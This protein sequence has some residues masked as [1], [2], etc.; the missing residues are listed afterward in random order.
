VKSGKGP[1]NYRT[2]SQ[3]IEEELV[4]RVMKFLD[5]VFADQIEFWTAGRAGGW[6]D[7]GEEP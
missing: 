5:E 3:E 4:E 1:R 2:L 6:H 7:R